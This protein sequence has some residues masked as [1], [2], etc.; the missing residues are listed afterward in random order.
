MIW[1]PQ[2]L[3]SL[4]LKEIRT[5]LV[6][7]VVSEVIVGVILIIVSILLN[8]KIITEWHHKRRIY[9]WLYNETKGLGY[10]GYNVGT[11]NDPRWFTTREIARHNNLTIERVNYICS[12][13]KKIILMGKEDLWPN[14]SLEEKWAIK[15]FVG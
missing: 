2:W 3:I 10:H 11:P 5:W 14:E 8:Q 1:T 13:H 6:D 7:N 9:N 12:I 15:E 4:N